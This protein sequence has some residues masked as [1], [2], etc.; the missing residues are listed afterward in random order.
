MTSNKVIELA[1]HISQRS[2]LERLEPSMPPGEPIEQIH[3]LL[4]RDDAAK[5]IPTLHPHSLYRLIK[6]GGWDQGMELVP[7]ASPGQIQIFMDLDCWQRDTLVPKNMETWLAVLIADTDDAHFKKV[8]R[9]LDAEIL[10]IFFKSNLQVDLVVEGEIPDYM[11]GN[12]RLSP[13]GTYALVYPEDED[14]AALMRALIERMFELDRVLVWTLFE[15]VR[16][17]LHSEMQES[18]YRWRTSRLEEFGFVGLDESLKVYAYLSPIQYRERIDRREFPSKSPIEAS[19]HVDLPTVIAG[20]IEEDFF[21]FKVLRGMASDKRLHSTLTELAAL[22]NRT[23]VADGVEPGELESGE[24]VVRRTVGYLSLGLE[25]LSRMDEERA[26]ELVDNLP[27]RDI[28]QVGFSLT[29]KLQSQSYALTR[30]PTLSIVEGLSFSLLNPD[31]E[32]LFEALARPRPTFAWDQYEHDIF[33]TQEQLDSAALR[34]GM[35]AFKQ[36]WLFGVARQSL[37]TLAQLVYGGD[38]I[39]EPVEVSFDVLFATALATQLLT[40]EPEMRPLTSPELKSLPAILARRP[41]AEDPVGYFEPLVGP[42]LVELPQAVATLSG[43][44]LNATLANMVDELGQV[45]EL[46][47]P[48][49]YTGLFLVG[50]S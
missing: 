32:A 1:E 42:M 26:L 29:R 17:E 11:E 9:D 48:G 25:F 21:F 41:W 16:W 49:F 27:L 19:R 23:L 24:E 36:L 3:A 33:Y 46:E 10:G 34:I 47:E 8:C 12:V 2:L 18:A 6:E 45:Q 44:W 35:V 7:Y 37:D 13:D 50:L 30:R 15:A 4:E 38:L 14:T 31:D 5:H 28:F 39:N 22:N 20:Q 43:R 40:G